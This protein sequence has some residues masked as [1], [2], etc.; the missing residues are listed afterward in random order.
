MNE[1][2][3][4]DRII[5]VCPNKNCGQKLGLPKTTETL[6]VN[7]PKCGNSFTYPPQSSVNQSQSYDKV[8]P[9]P[10]SYNKNKI[11]F[12][13]LLA[14]IKR[15]PIFFG[16]I[17]TC[18][19][20]LLINR[21][22][23]GVL[24]INNGLIITCSFIALWI[25][26]SWIINKTNEPGIKWYYRKWF[27]IITL[28]IFPPIGITLLWAG[29]RFSNATRIGLTI[30]FGLWFAIGLFPRDSNKFY[31][32][33]D[34]VEMILDL[35]KDNIYIESANSFTKTNFREEISI[36]ANYS[37]DIIL[38]IPAIAKTYGLSVV[39]IKSVDKKGNDIAQGSGFVVTKNG[40]IITNYHVLEKAHNVSIGFINGEV[41]KN[42]SLIAAFASQDIAILHIEGTTNKFSPVTLGN[43]D[44]LMAGERILAIGNPYG[45]ENTLSDGIISGIRDIKN[46]K[47]LQITSPISHGSSG[48]PLFN[49]KGEVIGITTIASQWGAQNLNFAIPINT[50]KYIIDNLQ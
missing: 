7:C 15:H 44:N 22:Q 6:K 33:K 4:K 37:Q 28:L 14:K 39:L 31:S 48:G 43:S 16:I 9:T 34:Q 3:I 20:L 46:I 50:L 26:G 47:F 49:M 8:Q 45:L 25:V 35:Q 12:A 40:G 11:R 38:T 27:V 42:V 32:Y 41:Y 13:W 2:D 36:V 19:F 18:W 17:T 30:G 24:N 1:E 10:K 23:K 5:V 21:L 29:S